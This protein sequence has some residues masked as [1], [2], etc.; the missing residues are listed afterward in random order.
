MYYHPVMQ[1]SF[2]QS[3]EGALRSA[4]QVIQG[5][6]IVKNYMRRLIKKK[7]RRILKNKLLF[8]QFPI[9]EIPVSRSGSRTVPNASQHNV[10]A[11][12]IFAMFFIVISLRRS[13]GEG[14]KQWKFYPFKNPACQLSE[15]V[16]FK[17]IRLSDGHNI[18]GCRNFCDRK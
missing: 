1:A 9:S 3:V 2:R 10:P 5:E 17:T 11:W 7:F 6:T 12:T 13:D 16:V 8:G 4:V 15:C 18:A 14:K